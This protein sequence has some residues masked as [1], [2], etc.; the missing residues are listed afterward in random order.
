MKIACS[1][2]VVARNG[3]GRFTEACDEAARRTAQEA[4]ER[5]AALSR[6]LAPIGHKVDGRTIPLRDSIF[7]EMT[8]ATS[9]RWVSVARH[10]L[11]TEY[12]AG[13]HPIT[14]DVSFFWERERRMWQP[15][16]NVIDHPGNPAQ[17][18]LRPAYE[19]VMAQV[20]DIAKRN[21]P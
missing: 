11:P 5:G 19:I 2:K 16:E 6:T 13:P 14:G 9:G 20:M 17:P 10:A 21:Y 4:V 7:S 12:G 1:N 3:F 8:G 18:F 15:G